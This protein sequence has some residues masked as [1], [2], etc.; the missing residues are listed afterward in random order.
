M[1]YLES[2]GYNITMNEVRMNNDPVDSWAGNGG[3]MFAIADYMLVVFGEVMP[4]Y[5]PSPTS[6]DTDVMSYELEFLISQKPSSIDLR[7]VYA[8][9]NRYDNWLRLAGRNY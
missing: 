3:W 8:V 4:D 5:Q 1:N 9:L 6:F 2:R 7:R